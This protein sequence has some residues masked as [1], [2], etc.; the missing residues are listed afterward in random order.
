[1]ILVDAKYRDDQCACVYESWTAL[2]SVILG[3]KNISAQPSKYTLISCVSVFIC[4]FLDVF[5]VRLAKRQLPNVHSDDPNESVCVCVRLTQVAHLVSVLLLSLLLYGSCQN[6]SNW[7]GP[8]FT[9]SLSF[10]LA[11]CSFV[12]VALG[13]AFIAPDIQRS[14]NRSSTIERTKFRFLF[15]ELKTTTTT[16]QE[17]KADVLWKC[18]HVMVSIKFINKQTNKRNTNTWV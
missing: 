3:Q 12:L 9:L 4:F 10:S 2:K 14:S 1:M 18:N 17:S 16:G 8:S 6:K 15:Y 7:Y 11:R 5:S 13:F